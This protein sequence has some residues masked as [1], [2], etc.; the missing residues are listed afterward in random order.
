MKTNQLPLVLLNITQTHLI[1]NI[2]YVR[3]TIS[4]N[5]RGRHSDFKKIVEG[6]SPCRQRDKYEY[7]M[8]IIYKEIS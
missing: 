1:Y 5:S 2:V 4:R 6:V 7:Y 3:C 8:H